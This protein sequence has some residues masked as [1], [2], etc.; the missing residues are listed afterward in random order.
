M[1]KMQWRRP[2]GDPRATAELWVQTTDDQPWIPYNQHPLAAPDHELF[3]KGYS[4][5]SKLLKLGYESLPLSPEDARSP[6]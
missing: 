5:F 4:T 6:T 1:A 2:K 3:S